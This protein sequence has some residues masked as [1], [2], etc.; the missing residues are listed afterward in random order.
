MGKLLMIGLGGC[1]GSVARYLL[2]ELVQSLSR[3]LPFP[4]GTLVV[5]VVGCLLIGFLTQF[6]EGRSALG[7]EARLFLFV[8]LLGGFT[9]YSTFG[10]ETMHLF[11]DGE[12]LLAFG[13]VV[14]QIVLGIGAAWIGHLAAL[15]MSR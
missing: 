1:L 10:K 11:K 12:H 13:N 5:N 8:G 15:A 7:T 2:S 6:L 4:F 9:T 3:N 14:A